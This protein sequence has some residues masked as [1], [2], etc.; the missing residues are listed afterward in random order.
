MLCANEPT[1]STMNAG[2]R[3]RPG[4]FRAGLPF[5]CIRIGDH[6][7]HETREKPMRFRGA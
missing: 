7:I 2:A 3:R 1:P 6:E 4:T 5:V